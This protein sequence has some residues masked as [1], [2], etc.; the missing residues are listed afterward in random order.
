[1]ATEREVVKAARLR[2]LTLNK[3][4]LLPI[5]RT[6]KDEDDPAGALALIL[7]GVKEAQNAN[8]VGERWGHPGNL[9]PQ[10]EAPNCCV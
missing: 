9:R 3:A 10:K 1:M 2:G 6:V 5:L 8:P 7:D 4:A